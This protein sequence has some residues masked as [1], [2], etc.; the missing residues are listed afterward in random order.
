MTD[1]RKY[2]LLMSLIALALAGV[3]ALGLPAS[4][5]HK[6]VKQ[7]LDLQGG[8]EV[9]LKAVPPKGQNVE[10]SKMRI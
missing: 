8:L 7:G 9:V 10:S 3:L 6:S 1:R 5:A 4:P 2:L